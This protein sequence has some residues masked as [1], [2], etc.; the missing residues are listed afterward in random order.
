MYQLRLL[1]FDLINTLVRVRVAP[2]L[3]YAQIARSLGVDIREADISR[4]YQATW[5]QKV[6]LVYCCYVS[7]G[8]KLCAV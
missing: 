7:A 8:V 5:R 1:T 2:A 3:Q 6:R 4:V